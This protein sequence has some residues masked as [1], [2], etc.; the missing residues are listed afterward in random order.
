M[1]Y[2]ILSIVVPVY[3]N[4]EQ[5]LVNFGGEKFNRSDIELIAVD[6]DVEHTPPLNLP[7]WIRVVHQPKPGS[8]AARNAGIAV[9]SCQSL[10]FTDVDCIISRESLDLCVGLANSSDGVCAG[11]IKLSLRDEC[12][13]FEKYDQLLGFDY[14]QMRHSKT[15]VTANLL[16]PKHTFAKIGLFNE[17]TFSGGDVEWTK[18]YSQR[19][20]INYVEKLEVSHPARQELYSIVTK[21]RRIIG[22][23]Y[24]LKSARTALFIALTPPIGRIINIITGE[25]SILDKMKMILI[26]M[27]LKAVEIF[28][29]IRLLIGGRRERN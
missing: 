6:N 3:K 1:N 5:F 2:P 13:I 11:P 24:F 26:L 17:K 8:Y 18:R 10:F 28:E 23:H 15:A 21:A 4:W 12:N 19:F 27:L 22:G 25:N 20:E 16:V 9:A 29:L 14:R 7:G